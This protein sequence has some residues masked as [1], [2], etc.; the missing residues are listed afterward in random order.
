MSTTLTAND[1]DVQ[2]QP[3]IADNSGQ[4]EPLEA[5]TVDHA[6]F[7]SNSRCHLEQLV[8]YLRALQLLSSA[9]QLARGETKAGKLAASDST[10]RSQ[11]CS[12]AVFHPNACTVGGIAL[13]LGCRSLAS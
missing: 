5:F 13:W 12:L 3:V 6:H 8:L 1:N 2:S 7:L 11:S 4:S 10:K 9:M